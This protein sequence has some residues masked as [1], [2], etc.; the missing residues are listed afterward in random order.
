MNMSVSIKNKLYTVAMGTLSLGMVLLTGCDV[1]GVGSIDPEALGNVPIVSGVPTQGNA[2]T[3]VLAEAPSEDSDEANEADTPP[4]EDAGD[5]EAPAEDSDDA[6]TEAPAEDTDDDEGETP[7]EDADDTETPDENSD[8]ADEANTP[9]GQDADDIETPGQDADDDQAEAPGQDASD[10]QAEAPAEDSDDDDTEA[11]A[12]DGGNAGALSTD[13]ANPTLW[14]AQQVYAQQGYYV[15]HDGKTYE[16]QWWVQ[17]NE[18][19][20][21][22]WN[23][24]RAVN[25][26]GSYVVY[27]RP[28]QSN[29]SDWSETT[30]Y[31]GADYY[32]R[33][34][35]VAYRSKWYANAGET[36]GVAAVWERVE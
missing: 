36:P 32:V 5:A 4:G 10:D 12:E 25:S 14:N 30:A 29:I 17:G 31:P 22:E 18:P 11:P 24:W 16:S 19:G 8:E 6:E 26:D 35:G 15:S 9:P 27:L 23:G 28:G 13:P 2:E 33:Y 3:E 20:A 34:N 7:G 1:L 21:A